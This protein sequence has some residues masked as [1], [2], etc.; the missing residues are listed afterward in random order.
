ML[1]TTV[2]LRKN[3]HRYDFQDI[4]LFVSLDFFLNI[5]NEDFAIGNPKV[6]RR[7]A[8]EIQKQNT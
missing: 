2:T 6:G 4:S 8:W 5:R 3:I 1:T 7:K